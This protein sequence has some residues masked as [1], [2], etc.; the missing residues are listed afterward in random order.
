MAAQT[1]KMRYAH[2]AV[3]GSAAYDLERVRE[4][5]ETYEEAESREEA[6][7]R[8]KV[9]KARTASRAV[10]KISPVS[11][12]GV[13][14]LVGITVLMLLAYV[15]LTELSA[16][17][18]KLKNQLSD[19]KTTN[20]QLVMAYES[21]FNLNEI[22]EYAKNTLGMVKPDA[23]QVQILNIYNSDKAVILDG[24]GSLDVGGFESV[25][26]FLLS[27]KEYF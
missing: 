26:S 3:Y 24:S 27:L 4:Y 11:V 13:L 18:T 17:T 2:R 23:S 8:E 21:S 15:Q 6:K 25:L 12:I 10:Y 7:T 19:L 20:E 16:E 14:L 5:Q 1:A 9:K 22:E